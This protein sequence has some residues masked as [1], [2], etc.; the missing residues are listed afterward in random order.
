MILFSGVFMATWQSH[1]MEAGLYR[2][3]ALNEE[4]AA[5]KHH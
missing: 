5:A 4:I 2:I 3:D 1:T